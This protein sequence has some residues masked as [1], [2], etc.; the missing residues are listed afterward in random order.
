MKPATWLVIQDSYA[1]CRCARASSGI[2]L[3]DQVWASYESTQ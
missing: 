3:F 2:E 1:P